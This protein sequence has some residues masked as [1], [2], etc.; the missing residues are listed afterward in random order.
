MTK[1]GGGD[2]TP[3]FLSPLKDSNFLM[4]KIILKIKRLLKSNVVK[5]Q[6]IILSELNFPGLNELSMKY[7]A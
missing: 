2:K 5:E 3:Q 6:P 4:K 7:L 1:R